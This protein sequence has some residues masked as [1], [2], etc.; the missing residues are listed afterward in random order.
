[1]KLSFGQNWPKIL[2]EEDIDEETGII[3]VQLGYVMQKQGREKEAA[4]I[5][6][7]V[8]HSWTFTMWDFLKSLQ[9]EVDLTFHK[10]AC[11]QKA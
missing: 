10:T 9:F 3:R 7:Q 11:K 4:T 1:M 8:E 5:Y 6:N 2:G